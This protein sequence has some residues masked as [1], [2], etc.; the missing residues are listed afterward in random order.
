M[1]DGTYTGQSGYDRNEMFALGAAAGAL[2]A[3]AVQEMIDR[4]RKKSIL[5]QVTEQASALAGEGSA[6][7]SGLAEGAGDYLADLSKKSSKAARKQAKR[8]R[9]Q[10]MSLK[11]AA[12]GALGAVAASDVVE[13]ALEL[14]EAARNV[15]LNGKAAKKKAGGWLQAASETAQGYVDAARESVAD[16]DITGKAQDAAGIARE[17]LED[18]KL[19]D[20]ARDAAAAAR[21]RLEEAHLGERMRDAAAMARERLEDVKIAERAREAAEAARERLAEAELGPKAREYAGVAAETVKDYSTKAQQ[22][23]RTSAE[24]LGESAALM[25]ESTAEGA[26]DLRKGVKKSVKRTRRRVTWGVRAFVV[27]LVIGVL[28]APQSGQRTRDMLQGIVEDLLDMVMPDDQM[29]G[30]PAR[31]RRAC[32]EGRLQAWSRPPISATSDPALRTGRPPE[33]T[34]DQARE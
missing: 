16:V 3:T 29:G 26:K 28:S 2:V 12:T 5:E 34:A 20:R 4:R 32:T 14:T 19:A 30:A 11:D 27:G 33:Q 13:Q 7:V 6:F 1:S 22:A 24:K 9:K 31:R 10:G 23:A 15:S 21:E 17:R 18:V 25:A 8:A